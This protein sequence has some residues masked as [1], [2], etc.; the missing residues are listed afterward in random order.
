MDT[1]APR[2]LTRNAVNR[3]RYIG[4]FTTV[5][6]TVSVSLL[7]WTVATGTSDQERPDAHP[8][9]E[10]AREEQRIIGIIALVVN[11]GWL[12]V[13]ILLVTAVK[14]R[15]PGLAVPFLVWTALYG[16]FC[17]AV[18]VVSLRRIVLLSGAGVGQSLL[19]PLIGSVVMCLLAPA[20]YSVLAVIVAAGRRQ[21]MENAETRTPSKT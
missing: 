11:I 8:L 3:T 15:W 2:C 17:L 1:C 5:A 4:I 19:T 13:A 10:A 18:V 12:V 21:M 16:P 20:A 7:S 9:E 14:K 6:A